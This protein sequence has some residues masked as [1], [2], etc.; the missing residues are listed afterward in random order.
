LTLQVIKSDESA[1]RSVATRAAVAMA[2]LGAQ[3]SGRILFRL[4]RA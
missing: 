1:S 3:Q 4:L 2:T